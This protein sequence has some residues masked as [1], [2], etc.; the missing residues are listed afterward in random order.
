MS[1]EPRGPSPHL[2]VDAVVLAGGRGSRLGGV[3][4]ASLRVSGTTLLDRLMTAL[5]EA[6]GV[7]HT[8]V[9]GPLTLPVGLEVL[10]TVEDPPGSGPV[11]ALDAGLS[12]L[13]TAHRPA[14]W[15]MVVAVDQPGAA[16][17][18]PDLL[19]AVEQADQSAD[20]QRAPAPQAWVPRDAEG[21]WQWLLAA[22]RTEPLRQA[23]QA[24]P[25]PA[26]V[27]MRRVFGALRVGDLNL[28]AGVLGDIDTPEDLAR[29]GVQDLSSRPHGPASGRPQWS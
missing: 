3:D 23:L 18:V 22:Y 24:L 10:Q 29:W 17:A 13:A 11:A 5:G 14:D 20:S 1:A 16:R 15:T 9:V 2:G 8:V 21:R 19:R 4:K 12:A 7:A 25:G 27:A 28:D 26:D 6:A